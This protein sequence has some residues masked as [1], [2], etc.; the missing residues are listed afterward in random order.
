MIVLV[1][2]LDTDPDDA[3]LTKNVISKILA[4]HRDTR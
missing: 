4:D 2:E 1:R 3:D